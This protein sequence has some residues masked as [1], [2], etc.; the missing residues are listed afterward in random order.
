M[1]LLKYYIFAFII[2]FLFNQYHTN[3]QERT[4]LAAYKIDSLWHII[5]QKG[6]LMFK[7]INLAAI[8]GF[9]E[10]Y[11]T[12]AKIINKDTVWGFLTLDGRFA[13]PPNSKW[14]GLFKNG[15]AK[16]VNW[17]PGVKD[18]KY[19]GYVRNDGTI[20]CPPKYLE[21]TEFADGLAFVM[22]FDERGFIDTNCRMVRE[23]SQG[24]AESFSENFAVVQD[25]SGNFGFINKNFQV[26]GK[27]EFEEAHNFSEGLARV[28]KNGLFGYV[29]TLIEFVIPPMFYLATDFKNTR[30]FVGHGEELNNIRWALIGPRGIML[31]DYIYI[32]V[33]DFSEGFAAVRSSDK[34]HYIDIMGNKFNNLEYDY[35]SSFVDGL[36]FA[37]QSLKNKK[38]EQGF[39][40][41]T[42]K[43][44]VKIPPKATNIIDLR[45]NKEFVFSKSK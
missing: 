13:I 5:D 28:V 39:I 45:L 31:S 24:F 23:F 15:Y 6:N 16:F 30:A 33:N 26:V 2:T 37:R 1:K 8:Q 27:L 34:W 22:N 36:A 43:F 11:F 40:D 21:A 9:S 17:Y 4:P 32:E 18:L 44:I 35:C 38:I 41:Y 19:H 20:I 7:P 14:V 25:S 12:V 10:G 3:G 29:D 42:G